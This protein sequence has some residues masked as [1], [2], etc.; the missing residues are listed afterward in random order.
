M[1]PIQ[2]RSEIPADFSF[3]KAVRSYQPDFDHQMNSG[4]YEALVE[5]SHLSRTEKLILTWHSRLSTTWHFE[6]RTDGS[7]W[8]ASSPT[9]AIH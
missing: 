2:A 7:V 8:P 6:Q 1:K 3:Q 4:I 9:S 5:S